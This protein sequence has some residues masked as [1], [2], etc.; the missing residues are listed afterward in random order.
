MRTPIVALNTETVRALVRN[1]LA[2]TPMIVH[3]TNA[4]TKAT[5][6]V[7]VISSVSE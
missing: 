4:G 3:S 6:Q 7:K 2:A 1:R 5:A